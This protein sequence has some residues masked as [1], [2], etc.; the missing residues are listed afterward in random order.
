M[1]LP[2]NYKYRVRIQE[3]IQSKLADKSFISLSVLLVEK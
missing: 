2:E 1:N 3:Q